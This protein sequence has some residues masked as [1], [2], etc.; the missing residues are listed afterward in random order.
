ML[1]QSVE[2]RFH[3]IL[4][5]HILLHKHA[6]T[7]NPMVVPFSP[8][9]QILQLK[10]SLHNAYFNVFERLFYLITL[11]FGKQILQ[12]YISFLKLYIHAKN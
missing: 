8:M 10:R 12:L 9:M 2:T 4:V 6:F 5:F 7:A 11:M 1:E 3:T